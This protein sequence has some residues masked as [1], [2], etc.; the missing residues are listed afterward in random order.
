VTTAS[1]IEVRQPLY[2]SSVGRA[3]RYT[4]YLGPL[5]RELG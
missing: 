5:I 1:R 3:Q 4:A 2:R